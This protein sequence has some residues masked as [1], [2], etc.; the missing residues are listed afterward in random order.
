MQHEV[1]ESVNPV[2]VFEYLALQKYVVSTRMYSLE[3]ERISDF[4]LFKNNKDEF[5]EAI[6]N[7]ILSNNFHNSVSSILIQEYNWD[8]L[9]KKM[10]SKINQSLKIDL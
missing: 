1:N 7:I 3:K 4:I 9:F 5:L 10:I 2:K 8:N 6:D